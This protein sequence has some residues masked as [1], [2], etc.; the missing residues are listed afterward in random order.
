MSSEPSPLQGFPSIIELPVFWGDMDSL[1]HVN[2]IIYFR[3]YESSR[4]D[5]FA[6]V[7][8]WSGESAATCGPIL[9]AARCDFRRQVNFPETVRIGGRIERMGKSSLDMHHRVVTL[10]DGQIAAEGVST[11]VY[12][13]YAAGR[14]LPIPPELRGKIESLEGKSFS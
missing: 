7:G 1:G 14:S 12:F 6:K 9:A 8:L 5:Y 4:I 2:N 13:D 11:V 10:G 3:W